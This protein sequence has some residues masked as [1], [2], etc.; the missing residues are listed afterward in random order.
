MNRNTGQLSPRHSL[1]GNKPTTQA[2]NWLSLG[3]SVDAQPLNTPGQAT[4]YFQGHRNE[5]MLGYKTT[6]NQL[7]RIKLIYIT[8]LLKSND[9]LEINSKNTEKH[10]HLE[11]KQHATK[12][13]MG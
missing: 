11:A 2:L 6:L 7:K 10:K 5:H 12:Q 9:I 13:C 8:Y 4:H 3:S 1:L